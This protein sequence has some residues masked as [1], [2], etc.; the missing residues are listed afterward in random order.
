[1]SEQEELFEDFS[2][3]TTRSVIKK[4][5]TVMYKGQEISGTYSYEVDDWG[6]F[7]RSCEI[8]DESELTQDEIDE[9]IEYIEN[10]I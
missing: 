5:W 2:S 8:D 4:N 9:I 7:D 10:V 3:M 6:Y 1:M